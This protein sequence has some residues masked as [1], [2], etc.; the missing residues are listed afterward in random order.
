MFLPI[1]QYF[2]YGSNVKDM[3][4]FKRINPSTLWIAQRVLAWDEMNAAHADCDGNGVVNETDVLVIYANVN[5]IHNIIENKGS[6][7]LSGPIQYKPCGS[8]TS[9][10]IPIYAESLM[11]FVGVSAGISW[12]GLPAGAE[13]LGFNKG[14]LYDDAGTMF[15]CKLNEEKTMAKISTGNLNKQ[16]SEKGIVAYMVVEPNGTDLGNFRPKV[17]SMSGINSGS[18]IFPMYQPNSIDY[19]KETEK[20]SCNYFND[21][22]HLQLAPEYHKADLIVYDLLGNI[23]LNR[24]IGN[25][26]EHILLNNL[27]SG[28]YV[29]LI[30]TGREIENYRFTVVK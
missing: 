1:D 28:V 6:S 8:S 27:N 15:F 11:P 24:T 17:E 5:E 22:L 9:V 21:M 19:E 4:T 25:S 2:D 18:Y 23:V 16:E 30:N 20:I 3:K 7:P 14:E 10:E 26:E 29:A 13:V 12:P